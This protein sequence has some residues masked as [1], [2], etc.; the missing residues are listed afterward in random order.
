MQY[1]GSIFLSRTKVNP[2]TK[3][4]R[5]GATCQ[6]SLAEFAA[7]RR[8]IKCNPFFAGAC[9]WQKILLSLQ[10]WNL[11]AFSEQIMRAADLK[12][13]CP[14]RA[15]P[16]FE[17]IWTVLATPSA[18]S[19][20]P[21]SRG[22]EAYLQVFQCPG[23]KGLRLFWTVSTPLRKVFAEGLKHIYRLFSRAWTQSAF[24]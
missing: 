4:F 15:S 11:F 8:Q 17:S 13:F 12:A 3:I 5:Q 19:F 21:K 14:K 10:V 9:T 2:L 1:V 16:F 18:K 22:V 24:R 7:R 6:K 20:C 23:Q